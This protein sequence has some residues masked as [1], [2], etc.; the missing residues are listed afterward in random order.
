MMS[1]GV[2]IERDINKGMQGMFKKHLSCSSMQRT[3]PLIW[4]NVFFPVL[5]ALLMHT[6]F[7]P[8]VHLYPWIEHLVDTD[9]HA[10]YVC[11]R[12]SAVTLSFHPHNPPSYLLYQSHSA[13]NWTVSGF[14]VE[15]I[16]IPC[17]HNH[18]GCLRHS[19]TSHFQ[20]IY[21]IFLP[22]VTLTPWSLCHLD[23]TVEI[24]GQ[25]H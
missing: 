2:M 19:H 21:N 9:G 15:P 1:L 20:A 24:C 7:L 22:S 18:C 23:T 5:V 3:A 13:S 17:G 10:E 25:K 16:W 4:V 11:V 6:H 12:T 14:Q 8:A